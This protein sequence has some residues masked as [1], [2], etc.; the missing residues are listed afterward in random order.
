MAWLCPLGVVAMTFPDK[1]VVE[2]YQPCHDPTSAHRILICGRMLARSYIPMASSNGL[3]F[4][5][6]DVGQADTMIALLMPPDRLQCL[7]MEGGYIDF[8]KTM[9]RVLGAMGDNQ[10]GCS[11]G[12]YD[13][14]LEME[15]AHAAN[16]GLSANL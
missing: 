13:C 5:I 6:P 3:R 8:G 12:C 7:V 16:I 10:Y 9:L 11:L 2:M 15:L 14:S 4:T 1:Y